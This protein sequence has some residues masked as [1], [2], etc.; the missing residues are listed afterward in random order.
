MA[1]AAAPAAAAKRKPRERQAVATPT[2]LSAEAF[3]AG[4]TKRHTRDVWIPE[5]GAAVTV[6]NLPVG[7][8]D[9]LVDLASKADERGALALDRD[10][11]H[12]LT[13]VAALESPKLDASTA[14]ETV[15]DWDANIFA[16]ILLAIRDLSAIREGAVDAAMS[17]FPAHS[18]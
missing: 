12:R 13:V 10:L 5:L 7:E 16:R 14:V 15:A 2:P 17:R 4:V 9:E 8:Y 11:L 6:R 18:E 3:I 1:A